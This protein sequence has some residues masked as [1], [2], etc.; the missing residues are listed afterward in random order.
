MM[1][2]VKYFES[3]VS[4]TKVAIF[5]GKFKPPHLGHIHLIEQA[6][7]KVDK[8]LVIIANKP[9]DGVDKSW[10][11]EESKKIFSKLMPN[12]IKSKVEVLISNKPSPVL[13]TYELLENSKEKNVDYLLIK[14]TKDDAEGDKRFSQAAMQKALDKNKESIPTKSTLTVGE[15]KIDPKKQGEEII[16]SSII[17]STPKNKREKIY[18]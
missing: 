13:D 3:K 17:R 8:V 11:P 10:T 5:P 15:I 9:Q 16:S 18:Q 1:S 12:D 7:K 6:A 4:R 2:L 14:S